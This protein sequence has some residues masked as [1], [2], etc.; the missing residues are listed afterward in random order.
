M[1]RRGGV[2]GRLPRP[3]GPGPGRAA[4]PFDVPGG[5]LRAWVHVLSFTERDAL[6]THFVA[7]C[8]ITWTSK[9]S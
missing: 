3:E 1:A 4:G 2:L 8:E 9:P 5:P 6:A 7:K